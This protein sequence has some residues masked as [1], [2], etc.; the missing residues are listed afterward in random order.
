MHKQIASMQLQH[1]RMQWAFLL[2]PV[3][4]EKILHGCLAPDNATP[5]KF[6]WKSLFFMGFTSWELVA[7]CYPLA[8]RG[9]EAGV[10]S[11]PQAEGGENGAAPCTRHSPKHMGRGLQWHKH[12]PQR[13]QHCSQGDRKRRTRL[14]QSRLEQTPPTITI[15]HNPP[16][17]TAPPQHCCLSHLSRKE[18]QQ[19]PGL[20]SQKPNSWGGG[21]SWAASPNPPPCSA[22]SK[23]HCCL[24]E[25]ADPANLFREM[26]C[27]GAR[28]LFSTGNTQPVTGDCCRAL[29][30]SASPICWHAW[31]V[32][33]S[34]GLG[35]RL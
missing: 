4:Q 31:A 13:Q 7:A 21:W 24:G 16:L 10:L 25:E 15:I 18:W 14:D 20:Q 11:P 22:E 6:L 5:C 28:R 32:Q 30:L 17:P 8:V 2:P 34:E 9:R 1:Q 23:P 33:D 19:V 29:K 26:L 27:F 35:R 3:K 12:Q